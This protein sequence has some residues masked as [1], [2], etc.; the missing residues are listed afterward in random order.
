VRRTVTRA[1]LLAVLLLVASAVRAERAERAE[2]AQQLADPQP[3]AI[4]AEPEWLVGWI[5]GPTGLAFGF[6]AASVLTRVGK[7][8]RAGSVPEVRGHLLQNGRLLRS[9]EEASRRRRNLSMDRET[10]T[11]S[12]A[13]R[14]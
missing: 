5:A 2:R 10:R 14:R 13:W 3:N 11:A 9:L 4:N 6:S 8:R 7:R 12:E 1:V